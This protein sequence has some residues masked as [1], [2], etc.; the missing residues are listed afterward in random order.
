MHP[1]IEPRLELGESSIRPHFMVSPQDCLGNSRN[2]FLELHPVY[3]GKYQ[4]FSLRLLF[5]PLEVVQSLVVGS[6]FIPPLFKSS[7]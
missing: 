2:H 4:F 6:W 3:G 5:L 7:F 1:R